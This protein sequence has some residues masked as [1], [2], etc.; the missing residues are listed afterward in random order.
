[1]KTMIMNNAG[2][3]RRFL[4][5]FTNIENPFNFS[6]KPDKFQSAKQTEAPKQNQHHKAFT[7]NYFAGPH[8]IFDPRLLSNEK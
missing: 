7:G 4:V 3:L 5:L 1:M 6:S 8:C 2:N